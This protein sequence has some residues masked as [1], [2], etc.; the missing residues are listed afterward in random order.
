[1]SRDVPLTALRHRALEQTRGFAQL[2]SNTLEIR[3]IER[4]HNDAERMIERFGDPDRLLAVSVSLVEYAVFG[5][6][7]R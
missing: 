6:G 5:E 1:V 3:E 7:A 4:S 2:S